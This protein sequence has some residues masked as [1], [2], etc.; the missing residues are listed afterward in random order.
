MLHPSPDR[1][2][3]MQDGSSM[4]RLVG[5]STPLR[6][7]HSHQ[8]PVCICFSLMVIILAAIAVQPSRGR[9]GETPAPLPEVRVS[10]DWVRDT[11]KEF[12]SNRYKNVFMH[13]S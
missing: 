9:A 4:S 8:P 1:K 5:N 10:A 13:N 3:S 7:H 6:S 2:T 11:A 12:Q